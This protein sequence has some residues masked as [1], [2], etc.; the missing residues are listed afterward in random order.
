MTLSIRNEDG[1]SMGPNAGEIRSRN[2]N[3]AFKEKLGN[4]YAVAS[5]SNNP[6][7]SFSSGAKLF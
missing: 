3:V 7:Y 2:T 5:P 1:G 6:R 4:S